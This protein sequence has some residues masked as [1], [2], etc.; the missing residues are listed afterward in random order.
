MNK[1]TEKLESEIGKA[2]ILACE[3]GK[4]AEVKHNPKTGEYK[5]MGVNKKIA[6]KISAA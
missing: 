6:K 4:S 3:D 5:V 2:V 1:D